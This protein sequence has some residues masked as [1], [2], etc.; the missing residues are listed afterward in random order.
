MLEG[1]LRVALMTLQAGFLHVCIAV[2]V[3]SHLITSLC[4]PGLAEAG[5]C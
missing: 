4:K 5:G 3:V 2:V 1:L